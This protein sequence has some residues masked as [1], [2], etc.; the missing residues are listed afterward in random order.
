MRIEWE[1]ET[2]T[3]TEREEERGLVWDE[4]WRERETLK[5]D[6]LGLKYIRNFRSLALLAKVFTSLHCLAFKINIILFMVYLEGGL[7]FKIIYGLKYLKSILFILLF[8]E[9]IVFILF[10]IREFQSYLYLT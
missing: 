1:T 7:S 5:R 4:I 2:E 10:S 8:L 9:E 6:I 3:D